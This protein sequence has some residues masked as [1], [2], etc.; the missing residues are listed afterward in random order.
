MLV[1]QALK[2][3]V[4]A[5]TSARV[6]DIATRSLK[7][8]HQGCQKEDLRVLK[9]KVWVVLTPVKASQMV[10]RLSALKESNSKIY[11]ELKCGMKDPSMGQLWHFIV[12][13]GGN[14][15]VVLLLH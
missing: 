2:V 8:R 5:S 7:D 14:G 6:K 13:G 4:K 12:G 11:S 10:A 9:D 1:S 15:Q 3:K